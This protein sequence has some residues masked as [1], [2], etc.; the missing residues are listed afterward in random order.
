VQAIA[1][2]TSA[3]LWRWSFQAAPMPMA[4]LSFFT[5]KLSTLNFR[6]DYSSSAR[7]NHPTPAYTSLASTTRAGHSAPID[8]SSYPADTDAP[9]F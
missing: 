4:V 1:V 3:L 6:P 8:V 9:S 7:S 2:G 5:W